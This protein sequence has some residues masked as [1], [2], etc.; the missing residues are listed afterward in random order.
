MALTYRPAAPRRLIAAAAAAI[1]LVAG[2]TPTLAAAGCGSDSDCSLNGVCDVATGACTCDPGWKAADCGMLDLLPAA[3]SVSFHGLNSNRSSWGGSV[4]RLPNASG[5]KVWA[6]FAAE[7]THDCTLR[8]WTTNSEVVMAVADEVTG[9]Y[10][11]QFQVIPPWAHNPE[12]I[13]TADGHV[14]IY[15]LGDGIPLHGP[16]VGCGCV[17]QRRRLR[18][19]VCGG[20]APPL[21]LCTGS[22]EPAPFPGPSAIPTAHTSPASGPSRCCL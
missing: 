16:E 8:H 2:A 11:E 20:C 15:T 21:R 1:L 12:A 10:S 14:V 9:P 18:G 5:A 4:L 3:S 19:A 17:P 13:L 22:Q 7:M 6:M